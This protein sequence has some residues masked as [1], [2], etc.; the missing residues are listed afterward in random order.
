MPCKG[1]RNFHSSKMVIAERII[2]CHKKA[3]A[4]RFHGDLCLQTERYECHMVRTVLVKLCQALGAKQSVGPSPAALL[5]R[6]PTHPSL[7]WA[8]SRH[9]PL[10]ILYELFFQLIAGLSLSPLSPSGAL[11]L[12]VILRSIG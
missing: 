4:V 11:S 5:S 6:T 12:I 3:E 7:N 9:C 8:A 10:L 2:I 1:R